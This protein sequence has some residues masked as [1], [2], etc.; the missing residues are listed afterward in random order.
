MPIANCPLPIDPIG[1]PY[2]YIFLGTGCATLSIV[3]RMI[4]SQ[5][6]T[7]KKILLIDKEPKTKNDRTWCFWESEPGFFED[8]VHK[9]W[10]QLSV[11]TYQESIPLDMG[12]YKYKMIRGLDFYFYCFSVITLQANIEVVYGEL[13]FDEPG[14]IKLDGQPLETGNA[15]V[16]NS[17]Q[18]QAENQPG[19]FYLKQHFKGWII[20]TPQHDFDPLQ[21]ILM[22]FRMPQDEGTTFVYLL[23][24]GVKLALVEYTLFT[25]H[26][27]PADEYNKQLHNY[28]S[29]KLNIRDY[30]ILE[31]EFGIIPMTNATFPIYRDGIYY[32]GTSGGQTKPST[33]Y[34]FQFI[35]KRAARLVD[36]LI[37]NGSPSKEKITS[38]RF[39]FYDST[40]LNILANNKLPGKEIFTRLFLK[41]KASAVFKFLDNETTL[42]EDLP[43][44]NSLPKKE[45]LWAGIKELI[46]LA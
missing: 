6:F 37:R 43:I 19:K 31:Q 25:K 20:E 16:F 5:Q 13:N 34:T 23:P 32:I 14:K 8:I 12:I 15:I 42:R 17:V 29:G 10:S 36:E 24:L 30:N 4:D 40:L 18:L 2:D 46:K 33:G 22:D 35:Q 44:I 26:L 11:E 3:M 38:K 21:G 9:K 45:F 28:L 39:E 41:N 27:L 7:S 1:S